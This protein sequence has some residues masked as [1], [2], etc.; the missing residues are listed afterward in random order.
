VAGDIQHALFRDWP[1]QNLW[2]CT[3][4]SVWAN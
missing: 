3:Y 4:Q 2:L 1:D